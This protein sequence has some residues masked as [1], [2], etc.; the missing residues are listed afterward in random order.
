MYKPFNK[1]FLRTPLF[2]FDKYY[3]V[4]INDP[5]FQEAL[6]IASPDFFKE[7]LDQKDEIK[8]Q[9]SAY[10]YHSRACTRSTPFGLF[11][12]CS[13]GTIGVNTDVQLFDKENYK[14]CTRLDMN[15]LCGLI[16][17]IEN[18][19]EIKNQ[20]KYFPNDSIY[21]IGDSVRYVEYFYKGVKRTHQITSIDNSIYIQKVLFGAKDG[22][23][24]YELA[25]LLV[26]DEIDFENAVEFINDLINAQ[27]LK[28]EIEPSITGGDILESLINKLDNLEY[29]PIILN[30]LKTIK[31]ELSKID[32]NGIGKNI[33][34]YNEIIK[35]IKEI[36][37][38]FELKYL[39]QT[40]LFKPTKKATVSTNIINDILDAISF[41]NKIT[42]KNGETNLSKFKKAF[43]ERYEGKEVPILEVLD[44]E[45]GIGYL[46]N[47]SSGDINPLIND[48]EFPKFQGVYNINFDTFQIELIKK[49]LKIINTNTPV[50]EFTDKDFSN[51]DADWSDLP[52]TLSAMCEIIKDEGDSRLV[53][54]VSIGGSC[55]AN[56]IGRFCH[57]DEEIYTYA[58]EIVNNE[59]SSN[60]NVIYAEIVH[61]PESRTGNILSKPVLRDFEIPFLVR[62][63]VDESHVFQLS[64]LTISMKHNTIIL[65]SKS[66]DVEVIP[67]LTTA[68]NYT[69]N[70]LP[71]Y[72][73]LCDLQNQN[74]RTGVFINTN[75]LMDIF[76]YFPR[77]MYKNVVLS[78]AMWKITYDEFKGLDKLDDIALLDSI[79][80]FRTTRNLPKFFVIPQ[81][82]NKLF[83][84]LNNII[85]IK[86]FM[87]VLKKQNIIVINE[88]LFDDG[89]KIIYDNDGV[90]V[91]EFLI[92]FF[93]E[94]K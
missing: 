77:I 40:D 45:L 37:C 50:I 62:P 60:S 23:S 73:F 88:F 90:F 80:N 11:A 47:S 32:G 15:Y 20:L 6:Y 48:L 24:I 21:L 76:D 69:N 71:V 7:C 81:S 28:S 25:K 43:Q 13:I 78:K 17:K 87:S 68:H 3:R 89:S 57:L 82:D 83:V 70:A 91:G 12:G 79:N 52:Q 59:Q 4:E 16:Q 30:K 74:I 65:K 22:K 85:S 2:S 18:D 75:G 41:L 64:D 34:G 35:T 92:S 49:Y 19:I 14:R 42:K 86:T 46:Q 5:I 27:V 29:K 9:I 31:I 66:H 53:S 38:K 84:D 1:F 10:K 26:D 33:K 8:I 55:A 93:K 61:L 54:L 36:D 39:F 51:F 58:H 94:N 72:Q 44:N 63:G 67:R 56:L